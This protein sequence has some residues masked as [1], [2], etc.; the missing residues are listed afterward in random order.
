LEVVGRGGEI[1]LVDD[2]V[3]AASAAGAAGGARIGKRRAGVT[4]V[5]PL[6]AVGV[7]LIGVER[8][9]AVVG[10]VEHAVGITAA[11]PYGASHGVERLS[12]LGVNDSEE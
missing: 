6:V 1:D 2:E 11:S 4:A 10:S 5:A 7:Q 3:R 9:G 8:G 12:A